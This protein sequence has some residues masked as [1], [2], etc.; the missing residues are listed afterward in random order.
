MITIE[1][2]LVV[3]DIMHRRVNSSLRD[4]EVVIDNGYMVLGQLHICEL[5]LSVSLLN[6]KLTKL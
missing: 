6:Y 5:S 1:T 2:Y 4:E 3:S